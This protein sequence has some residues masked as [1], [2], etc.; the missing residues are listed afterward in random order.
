MSKYTEA[1]ALLREWGDTPKIVSPEAVDF[2]IIADE[3]LQI[4]DRLE[5]MCENPKISSEDAT[6]YD[7]LYD[8]GF[9]EGYN[10]ACM[11]MRGDLEEAFCEVIKTLEEIHNE[12]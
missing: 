7:K 1:L 12:D 3:A 10:Y 11:V 2:A 4:A 9:A 5:H 8:D 6:I